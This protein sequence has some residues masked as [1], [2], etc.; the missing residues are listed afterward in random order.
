MVLFQILFDLYF[1]YLYAL[2]IPSVSF[3]ASA[4]VV[5]DIQL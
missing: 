3:F 2:F 4:P 5:S 1:V